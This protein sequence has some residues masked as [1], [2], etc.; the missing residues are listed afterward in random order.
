MQFMR[1]Y[2]QKSILWG[3][4]FQT[5]FFSAKGPIQLDFISFFVQKLRMRK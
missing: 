2:K 3:G 5:F 1:K 4:I